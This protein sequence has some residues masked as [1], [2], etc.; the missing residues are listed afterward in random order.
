METERL[1]VYP[2]TR[3]QMEACIASETD[4]ELKAA[5]AE[6]LAGCL[7]C[8]AQWNWYA[9]W[10]IERKDGTHVGDLC[11]KGLAPNGVVEI[12]YGISEA[13]QG[14][15]YATEAVQAA[16][17]WALAQPEVSAVEAETDAGNAASQRVLEKCGFVA[18]GTV[19]D[20][21]PRF[22]LQSRKNG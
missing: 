19:G 12:G 13:Y 5:Y 7:S 3:E 18:N 9:M 14:R 4:A 17:A 15:G 8:P 1:R 20:E 22:T 16:L 11:F 10:M 6:M 2:A 21:G